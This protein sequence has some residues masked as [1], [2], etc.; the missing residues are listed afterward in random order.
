MF[1]YTGDY[2]KHIEKYDDFSFKSEQI[3]RW[4]SII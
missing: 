1:P 2:V 4:I 3:I